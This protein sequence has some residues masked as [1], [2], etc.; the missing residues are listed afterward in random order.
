M[1]DIAAK[2]MAGRRLVAMWICALDAGQGGEAQLWYPSQ[3]SEASSGDLIEWL[4][5]VLG[6]LKKRHDSRLLGDPEEPRQTE[7]KEDL[8][9][10]DSVP[11]GA[12]GD[13]PHPPTE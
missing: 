8:S 9:R 7:K 3:M 5:F 10:V 1:A 11:D 2:T 4:E 12:H 13:L 6:V